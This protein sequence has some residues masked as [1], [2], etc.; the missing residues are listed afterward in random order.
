MPINA[1]ADFGLTLVVFGDAALV[2][3]TNWGNAP[4]DLD[5]HWL[6]QLPSCESLPAIELAPGQQAL[7]GLAAAEPPSLAG[8]SAI[9]DL[10]PALGVL[11]P[12][13]GEVGL[14]ESDLVDDPAEIIEDPANIVAYVAWGESDHPGSTVA[15][16]AGVWDGSAVVV[17]DEAPSISSGV[18]PAVS[19]SDWSADVGG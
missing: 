17:F 2:V 12:A 5:G 19:S 15:G 9:V 3:I 18:Y 10:G 16:A 6:C 1:A 13:G 14:Y 7:I 4:G 8:I 11:D